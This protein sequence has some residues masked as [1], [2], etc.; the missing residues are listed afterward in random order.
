[1]GNYNIRFF[2]VVLS[3]LT[4]IFFLSTSQLV[5]AQ[6]LPESGLVARYSFDSG[7]ANDSSGNNNHGT[8]SGAVVTAGKLGDALSFDGTNAYVLIPRQNHDQITVSAWFY[9]NANDATF[10]DAIVGGWYWATGTQLMEGF[11]IRFSSNAPNALLFTLTTASVGGTRTMLTSSYAFADSTNGWHH[12][13]GSYEKSTGLQRLY[14]D[15]ALRHTV[16][17]PAG[18]VI[19]PLTSYPDMRIG[20]SR[21]NNG[22]FNGKIDEVRIYNRALTESEILSLYGTTATSF[23]HPSS[24]KN[25]YGIAWRDTARNSCKYAKQMGYEYLTLR[26]YDSAA[27]YKTY[28]ECQGLNFFMDG[29]QHWVMGWNSNIDTRNNYTPAQID[30]YNKHMTWKDKDASFPDNLATGWYSEK[31]GGAVF[32]PNWDLQQQAVIDYLVNAEMSLFRSYKAAG[33]SFAGYIIDVAKLT[34]DFSCYDA[35]NKRNIQ[36]NL[37]YW[38]DSDSGA[39]HVG[40]DGTTTK[41]HSKYSD[42]A[43][44]YYKQLRARMLQEFPEGKWIVEPWLL[45]YKAEDITRGDYCVRPYDTDEWVYRISQRP[46]KANLIPDM[47]IQESFGTQFVDEARIFNSGLAITP[48]MVGSAQ[49]DTVGEKEN[50]LIAAKAGINGAWYNWFGHFGVNSAN[51][52]WEK[53]EDV[54]PRLKLIRVIPNWDNLRNVPLL[55]RSW[56]GI[57]TDPI[58][59]S[60]QLASDPNPVSYFDQHVMYSRH[61]KTKK[62]FAV[63]NDNISPVKL[64]PGET[65]TSI[66]CVDGYFM[67]TKGCA[68]EFDLTKGLEIKSTLDF[69]APLQT[70]PC[71]P[72]SIGKG[73]IFT[74]AANTVDTTPPAAPSGVV[75]KY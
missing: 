63:F 49:Q 65:V 40:V 44:E 62:I 25:H 7:T 4:Q 60:R 16:S 9:K 59:Q 54:Y 30:F 29:P 22:Y 43:A 41:N 45:Y 34:G 37:A 3:Y 19:V 50:R 27:V 17:H 47:L 35:S 46:D 38:T 28:S 12:L 53:I 68:G 36:K 74:V 39:S 67:E 61:W 73:Y 52:R 57:T 64:N 26:I 6:S 55:Q 8:I 15:G 10:A 48:N 69:C 51:P 21:V 1:M 5:L 23:T 24:W 66:E 71:I 72:K 13:V 56:N 58:Y 18:N 33:M 32:E 70:T 42:G 2:G 20:Y 31:D 14:V 75:V 11:D